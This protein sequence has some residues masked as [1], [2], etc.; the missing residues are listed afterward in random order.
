MPIINDS[1][2]PIAPLEMSGPG[3]DAVANRKEPGSPHDMEGTLLIPMDD[4]SYTL[5]PT[6]SLRLVRSPFPNQTPTLEQAFI[7]RSIWGAGIE[8]VWEA[9]PTVGHEEA[10]PPQPSTPASDA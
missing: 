9:V 8:I 6:F 10:Y 5:E 7:K 4:T 3:V 2:L 1:E